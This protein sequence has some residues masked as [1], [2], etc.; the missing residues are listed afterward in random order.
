MA[1]IT[2]AQAQAM[3]RGTA[4]GQIERLKAYA[5]SLKKRCVMGVRMPAMRMTA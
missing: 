3:T 4:I 1:G 2:L 5:I